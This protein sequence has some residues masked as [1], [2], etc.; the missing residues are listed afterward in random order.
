MPSKVTFGNELLFPSKYLSAF[1]CK[2]A[3]L[4]LTVTR[5]EKQEL[6]LKRGGKE[7][8][9]VLSFS[10]SEKALVL[11]KTNAESIAVVLGS[12]RAEDW[13][14]KRITFFP[15]KTPVGREIVDCIRVREQKANGDGFDGPADTRD[16]G[17]IIDAID[18]V[19]KALAWPN[20]HIMGLI[21]KNYQAESILHLTR[22]Q[23]LEFE[24]KL[25]NTLA[26]KE[27]SRGQPGTA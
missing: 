8:K 15:T 22:E 19:C 12:A 13:I 16:N 4:T 21:A 25:K 26:Q 1:D 9:P 18:G 27:A 5:I 7:V 11:N 23:L 3:D 6:Q 20:D 2:G 17:M 14:G 24:R 10:E